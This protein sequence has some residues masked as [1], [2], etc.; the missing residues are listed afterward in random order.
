MGWCRSRSCCLPAIYLLARPVAGRP[1]AALAAG[2]VLMS[3]SAVNFG[4]P[5]PGWYAM[6]L[7]LL[8]LLGMRAWLGSG[9]APG[10]WARG[11]RSGW[12]SM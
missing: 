3:D 7:A 1:V 2:M 12:R 11:S 4:M 10:S 8:G 9:R 6:A 5:H